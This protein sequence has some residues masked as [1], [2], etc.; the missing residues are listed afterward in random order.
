MSLAFARIEDL[1]ATVQPGDIIREALPWDA[2][3][4]AAR[5]FRTY[6]RRGGS[7]RSPLPDFYIG[8]HAAVAGY[9][10][11]TRYGAVPNVFPDAA[12]H[13]AMMTAVTPPSYALS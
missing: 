9:R 11:L 5:S 8:A 2:A 12:A 4:L 13:F 3:F 1:D 10:L 7:K 6:R